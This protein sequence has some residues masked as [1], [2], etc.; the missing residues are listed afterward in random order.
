MRNAANTVNTVREATARLLAT[1]NITVIEDPK[2]PSAY[3]DLKTRT[4][5]LPVWKDLSQEMYD[6]LVGHEVGHA[7]FTPNGNGGWVD[8]AKRIAADAG[9]AGDTGAEA[10]AQSFLN[11]VED[12]RIERL[13]KDRYP[14]L[15]RDFFAAY[16][17]FAKRDIFR[18]G[19]QNIGALGLAD[20]L[21]IHF[22]IG[23]TQPVPFSTAERQFV[24]RMESAV[25][26]EEVVAIAT[27]LFSH[28]MN[29]NGEQDQGNQPNPGEGEEGEEGESQGTGRGKG[30]AR[31]AAGKGKG[32]DQTGGETGTGDADGEGK[33][34]G[35][36]SGGTD[37]AGHGGD[38][39]SQSD[40][41]V[42]TDDAREGSATQRTKGQGVNTAPVKP[43]AAKTAGSLDQ[44][45]S[46]LRDR[47]AKGRNYIYLP[48]GIKASE[49]TIPFG[50]FIGAM[51]QWEAQ[52]ISV[53][54]Y[55]DPKT[56][57][58]TLKNADDAMVKLVEDTRGS[59]TAFVREFEMLKTADEHRRTV[60]SKSGR[61]DM[62]QAWKFRISEDLFKVATTMR[63]G[64]NHGF[65]M[66]I[67]WSG[68]MQPNMEQTMRQLYILFQFCR[69]V[70][71]PF[72]VYAFG[73]G[74]TD[75]SMFPSLVKTGRHQ[76]RLTLD[77][78]RNE[79]QPNVE[80][81]H[82]LSS[83]ASARDTQDAFRYCLCATNYAWGDCTPVA[84]GGST[85]L[86]STV[87]IARDIVN[88]F[89]K[90]TKVQIVN[91]VIL[92]DGDATDQL[93]AYGSKGHQSWNGP[94]ILR[95]GHREWA[96]ENGH[97]SGGTALLLQWFKANTGANLV[98]IFV[99]GRFSYATHH[100][101]PAMKPEDR[102]AAEKQWKGDGWCSVKAMGFDQYFVLRG[103]VVDTEKA[104]DE[105]EKRDA[106]GMTPT[107]IKNAYMKAV[108]SRNGARGMIHRFVKTVA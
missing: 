60:E 50:E 41:E 82:I 8:A 2:A 23:F 105:F 56:R 78:G 72:D 29:P 3:F 76:D 31:G 32:D 92:T 69:K 10:A 1:E 102:N 49:F 77:G 57:K 64:K 13:I 85:P 12:A 81:L 19:G 34:E 48:K 47:N 70:G 37:A 103:H 15:R 40:G 91:T 36:Q 54:G 86:D 63:D 53:A 62:D 7:L 96:S 22:K 33:G 66:F 16:T 20:R 27:D 30:N 99:A 58:Q 90:A 83:R 24:E 65:V 28:E 17:E 67:D 61:L 59:I 52:G 18:I 9:F 55:S 26:W 73:V 42:N 45:S 84:L 88:E 79:I 5:G 38:S 68:S 100:F 74:F 25:T 75:Q 101:D 71:I 80:L 104:M 11:V 97:Y 39:E 35:Q 93:C 51:R 95:D 4:L 94:V 6:M 89:R 43:R 21:N 107:Q 14:G 106:G 98:G 108:E 44:A 46:D 87:V